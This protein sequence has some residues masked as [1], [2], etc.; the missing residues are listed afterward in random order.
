MILPPDFYRRPAAEVARDLLGAVLLSTV[1]GL[2]CAGRI[3]ETEAYI[4]PDDEASHAA[5]R[6]G[7]TARNEAMFGSP[8]IAY[9][10]RIYGAHWCL[11]AVTDE[12]GFP[13][14]VLIRA[15]EP[16][17]GVALAQARRSGRPRG[18][19]MRGPGNLCAALGITGSLN[20]HPL[21][22]PPLRM[23]SGDPIPERA[24][25]RGGRIGITRDVDLPLRFWLRGDV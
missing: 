16:V 9:V 21:Q 1:D 23:L 2:P 12:S 25:E 20:R 22:E 13:A 15:A 17:E 6:I 14:A 24:V 5:A 19:L 18:D 3:V 4:G 7:R 11:N 8:G 10:Y